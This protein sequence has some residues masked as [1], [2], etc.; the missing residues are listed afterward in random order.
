[1]KKNLLTIL[2]AFISLSAFSQQKATGYVY[3]DVNKNGRKDRREAG[4]ANVAVS[5]GTDVVLTDAKGFYS[6]PVG[7]DNTIFVIKPSGY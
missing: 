1:M 6:L 7:N 4:I 3:D 2:L 5:N